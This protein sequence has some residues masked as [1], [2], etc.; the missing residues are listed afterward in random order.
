MLHTWY[1]S[2]DFQM[3]VFSLLIII[4]LYKSPKLG[5]L[6]AFF[7]IIASVIGTFI[8]T[9]LG[10]HPPTVIFNSPIEIKALQNAV[11]VYTITLPHIAVYSLGIIAG[12]VLFKNRTYQIRAY[13]VVIAWLSIFT[14][15]ITIIFWTQKWN[16]GDH[17]TKLSSASF[18]SWHRIGWALVLFWVTFACSTN[19]GGNL[20]SSL[21]SV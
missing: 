7:G 16:Q 17:W 15:A 14:L 6:L 13:I 10:N 2:A 1:L 5:C 11:T 12:Y 8:F 21:N 18:A 4:V 20:M 19:H 9:Y 3:Y